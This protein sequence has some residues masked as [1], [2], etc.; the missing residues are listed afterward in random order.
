MIEDKPIT[1]NGWSPENS[2]RVYRGRITLREA[3]ARSSNAATVRLEQDVGRTNVIR[4][5]RELG[6]TTPLPDKPSLA[7]GTAGVSLLELTSAYAAV[8][9]GRYPIV[10]RGLPDQQA[11][12]G[13]KAIF[14]GNGSLDRQREWAPMLDLLYAAANNGTGRRAALAVPT[15][16]KTGTT[17]EN[18]DA[19]FIGFAGDLVVGV[20][21]GRDDNK[22]LGRV[23]GGTVPAEIWRNFMTS[24]I[25]VDRSRGPALPIE[26]HRRDTSED[27]QLKSPLPPDW[28]N[29]TKP[30]RDLF[31]QID[32]LVGGR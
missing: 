30:L 22:S 12:E 1:I 8:A 16:G 9:S 28:S 2:D 18:R 13:L 19:V 3:F 26:F 31:Q 21:V 20:W 27:Q 6:I 24:A 15:F 11:P 29:A 25:A 5:A 32:K 4:T 14:Q 7:L 17:Q 10:A 23:S